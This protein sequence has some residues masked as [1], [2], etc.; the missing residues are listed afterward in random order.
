MNPKARMV[1]NCAHR[2]H[3]P[4]NDDIQHVK[5]KHFS[6]QMFIYI[7]YLWKETY[8]ERQTLIN[9]RKVI[10]L[11]SPLDCHS[12]FPAYNILAHDGHQL[13]FQH[14]VVNIDLYVNCNIYYYVMM[15]IFSKVYSKSEL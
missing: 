2:P 3:H 10:Y 1:N 5:R 13:E 9:D 11:V 6:Y 14:D 15:I 4:Q 12:E 8:S 7:Y